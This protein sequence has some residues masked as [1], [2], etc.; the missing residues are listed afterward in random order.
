MIWIRVSYEV[1]VDHNFKLYPK[2]HNARKLLTM[3]VVFIIDPLEL[4]QKEHDTSLAL[5][6]AL[7][8]RHHEIFCLQQTQL[9]FNQNQTWGQVHR[10]VLNLQHQPWYQIL[11]TMRM[12]LSQC[13]AVWMRKDPPV[14]DAYLYATQLL[15]LIPA[16]TLVVNHPA[17]LRSANEKLYALQFSQWI[18]KTI[19]SSDRTTLRA[20]LEQEAHI[21]LKPLGGKGGEGILMLKQGDPNTNSLIELA[22]QQ[23]KV[24]IM[25]QEY[26]PAAQQGDK[27]ILL[28]EGHPIGA[29]NRIPGQGDFRGNIAAGGHVA[30]AEVTEVEQALCADL[31]PK[32][33]QDQLYFVGIDVIGERLTEVNV[34]SPTMLQEMSTLSG[35]NLADQVA[36]WLEQKAQA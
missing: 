26:L 2:K 9:Y 10:L 7:Q 4:L 11:E 23:G 25:A 32:L 33:Q 34:T 22:T 3:K 27:R 31:A 30:P 8:Q 14:D 35:H 36:H 12:P 24:P 18:P 20:F 28:L 19:V 16:P 15:D 17:S 6:V 21:V 1:G 5:M 29:V 13:H